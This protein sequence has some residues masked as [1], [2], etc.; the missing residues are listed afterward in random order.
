M[1][2][3]EEYYVGYSRE[4]VPYAAKSDDCLSNRELTVTG[5]SML[6]DGTVLAQ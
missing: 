5:V 4:Y 2:D 3:G 1:I 6:S